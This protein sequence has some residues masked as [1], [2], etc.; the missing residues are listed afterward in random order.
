M[1]GPEDPGLGLEPPRGPEGNTKKEEILGPE[2]CSLWAGRI[3]ARKPGGGRC[4]KPAQLGALELSLSGGCSKDRKGQQGQT[5]AGD[6]G[7]GQ[8]GWEK[9][10]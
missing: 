4:R 3:R 2:S 8:C 7:W 5:K 6:S 9:S 1:P 10:K